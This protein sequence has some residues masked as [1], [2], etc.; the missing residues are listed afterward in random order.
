VL[1][2]LIQAIPL[3]YTP[4]QRAEALREIEA[5]VCGE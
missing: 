3:L 4:G 2:Q 5:L 1:R